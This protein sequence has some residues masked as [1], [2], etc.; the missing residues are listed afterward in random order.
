MAAVTTELKV[1]VKAVGKGEVDKLSKSLNDLGSKAAA[2]ANR[3]FRELS[4]ELKKI[5]RNST[6]SIANLRGYRNA[7]RDISEQVKIGSR[8]FKVATENAKRLDAQLQKAQGRGAPTGFLGRIGGIRGA[9]KG[10]GAIAAGGVFGGPEGAL[11][12]GIGLAAGGPAGAAVGAAIGA[13][14][15][16][17]RQALG[18]TA[19]YSANLDKLRIAL[20][21]VTTSSEEYQQGLSFVQESTERFA[22]PQEILTRQFTKL[23]ASVQG[24]GG[25]LDDTKTAFNG[26]V[27]AVRATGGSLADVDAA[28]TATAQVF[29]KG[30]V[31]AEELRQ[32]IGERLPG[33]FTLFAESMG[34]TPAELDKALEQGKVSLQDFQGF[35]KAIFDRYGKN[36]EAI[37]KSPKAAGDQLQVQL[38]QLQESVGR[39]LQPIGAFFQKTF[40]AIVRDITRATN[41]LARFL[42]MSFDPEKL[43]K[44]EAAVARETA[45]IAGLDQG[46][47]RRR[48]EARLRKARQAVATQER[49]R[50]ASAVDVQQPAAAGGFS[51]LDLEGGGTDGGRTPADTSERMV[52]L[53]E[54]LGEALQAQNLELVAQTEYLIRNEGIAL[55]F[56]E[57]KITATKRDAELQKSR[58]RLIKDGI[59]L[60]KQ[61]KNAETELKK[62][63]ES[64]NEQFKKIGKTIKASVVDGLTAAITGAQSLGEALGNVLRQAGQL[65]ISFGLKQIFPFL[66]ANGNVYDQSGFVP[67]AKGG[68]VD[69][70]TLFP[71]AKGIGLMGEAGPEAI[72]PLRRGPSGRLGV[73]AAGGGVGNVVVNVDAS[74]TAVQGDSNQADQLGKAIGAAVQA[75]LLKQ[76]RPGGMLAGV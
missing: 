47:T 28:L 5:Q 69:K 61:A 74:G 49:L 57:G 66:N 35:A 36:A 25:N 52:G 55:K 67:F 60:R 21:G 45:L 10:V 68:V 72:M 34:L 75:E 39:L 50:D 16:G 8:E 42:N 33:A 22:I 17:I 64:V 4:L 18:A 65:F 1:L 24:A 41:A 44:A 19:E 38:Q 46:P 29:S 9:A 3:Q 51:A 30:K 54:R 63:T 37:A 58:N 32:Q 27:A 12:A 59:R 76:K 20:K 53:Q 71:F 48:A 13:Q 6:Q 62:E 2:P 11:G 70:P 14:V 40:G 73:E 23:Q 7:W 56:E 26:I 43:A 31:S 15:G